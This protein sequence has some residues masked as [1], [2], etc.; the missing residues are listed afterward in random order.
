MSN[1]C[2]S[3]TMKAFS[4]VTLIELK[5]THFSVLDQLWNNFFLDIEN[6]CFSSAPGL[7]HNLECCVTLYTE[8]LTFFMSH[9]QLMTPQCHLQ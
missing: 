3:V 6:S 5:K 8:F 9:L 2:L 1:C 4:T 7:C